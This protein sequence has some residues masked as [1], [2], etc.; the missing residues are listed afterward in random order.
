MRIKKLI[1]F[2]SCALV[3]SLH[4]LGMERPPKAPRIVVEEATTSYP[5]SPIPQERASIPISPSPSEASISTATSGKRKQAVPVRAPKKTRQNESFSITYYLQNNLELIKNKVRGQVLDL[6]GL[7]ISNLDGLL[8]IPG[9]ANIR[10]INLSHNSIN[11]ITRD[12]FSHLS[13]LITLDLSNNDIEVLETD[14]FAELGNLTNLFLNNNR[15]HGAEHDSFAHLDNLRKLSLSHNRFTVLL[16]KMLAGVPHLEELHLNDNIIADIESYAF[17]HTP[18]LKK[19]KLN[20]NQL[21]KL[22][23]PM[24]E[25]AKYQREQIGGRDR[26][27]ALLELDLR[28]N[29]L[30]EIPTNILVHLPNI[31]RLLLAN[32]QIAQITSQNIT[33]LKKASSLRMIDVANNQPSD[34]ALKKLKAAL[35][36]VEVIA[37]VAMETTEAAEKLVG[38]FSAKSSS[39][40]EQQEKQKKA[41]QTLIKTLTNLDKSLQDYV[42]DENFNFE[43]LLQGTPDHYSYKLSNLGLTNLDGILNVPEIGSA[44]RIFLDK[45]N[46]KTISSNAFRGLPLLQDIILDSNSL[47]TFDPEAFAEVPKLRMVKLNNNRLTQLTPLM[48]KQFKNLESLTLENNNITQLPSSLFKDLTQLKVLFLN[49]NALTQ[50]AADTFDGLT[51]LEILW[52]KNNKLTYLN[53]LLFKQLKK[54]KD[55]DLTGN[56]L[57]KENI[58]EIKAALPH[59]DIKF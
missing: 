46:L 50:L 54:L 1:L 43:S 25:G 4:L 32:N 42:N 45:N 28:D 36:T 31:T 48:M 39:D 26:L 44:L 6:S 52:I 7:H 40:I 37:T 34:A 18:F 5:P 19:L 3:F 15:I 59:V 23:A 57:T 51:N 56:L 13:D 27:N 12:D 10:H 17:S 24:F 38:I 11:R 41:G 55:I 49:N 14:G 30:T 35:P 29:K 9:I 33:A 2:F 8:Q 22:T 58:N 16:Q 21:T 47:E 20:K 53:P